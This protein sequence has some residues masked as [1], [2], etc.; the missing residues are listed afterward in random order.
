[1]NKRLATITSPRGPFD[2]ATFRD[3]LTGDVLPNF[4]GMVDVHHAS[5]VT[6]FATWTEVGQRLWYE[7]KKGE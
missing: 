1:M 5:G 7:F 6:R 4:Q 3:A 2:G